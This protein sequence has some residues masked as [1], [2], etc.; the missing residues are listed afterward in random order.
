K[1][2]VPDG[3]KDLAA[4]MG[5]EIENRSWISDKTKSFFFKFMSAPDRT[6]GSIETNFSSPLSIF[7]NPIT[8]EATNFS[9][10]DIRDIRK[11]PMSIYLGLTPDALITHEKIVNLF[12]SLL[13]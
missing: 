9:D 3:G 13:V 7:S 11:K 6:R 2:S 1:T 4:W 12:F 10:F 5:Q 8:A